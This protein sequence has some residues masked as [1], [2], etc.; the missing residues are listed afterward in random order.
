MP[1]PVEGAPAAT[2]TYDRGAG[3]VPAPLLP[4]EADINKLERVLAA[5]E[6]RQPDRVP[7]FS[8]LF[9]SKPID[10]A[11]GMPHLP[12]YRMVQ[13]P[14]V[15]RLVDRT[16]WL[17]N[18]IAHPNIGG[19][20][21]FSN[22]LRAD[23]RL[24]FDAGLAMYY[25]LKLID[26]EEIEDIAGRRYTMCD[27]GFGG[28]YAMYREGMITDPDAWRR[29][30]KVDPAAYARGVRLLFSFLNFVWGGKI[31]LV[32][33]IGVSMQQDITEG[34]GFTNFVR[35]AR[36]DPGFL[37]DIIEYKTELAVQ[38]MRAAGESGVRVIWFGDDLAFKSGSML[39]PKMLEGLFGE[40]YRRIAEAAHAGGCRIVFH[41][42]GNVLD[43]LTSMA[44][45]GFDGVHALE[46]TAG[47]TLAE[48]RR[49]IGDRLCLCGN[50]DITRT[51]VNGTREEVFREVERCI[52]DGSRGGGF[53]LAP[54]NT[55]NVVSARNLGWMVEAAREYG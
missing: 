5:L 7:T 25:G 45:W 14:L 1:P 17:W 22:A 51:L 13:R 40:S 27:D 50:V 26:H 4:G 9:D 35:W 47:V 38:A 29:F 10:D 12:V 20:A 8:L 42:C 54:T 6:G 31:A 46:P 11:L 39:S 15:Q 37:R 21:F 41:S 18:T 44:D 48:A 36:R 55:S 3:L 19:A 34:M 30:K 43:L 53:I 28:V 2:G 49:R 16:T 32:A 52:V 24:G 23:A 33:S